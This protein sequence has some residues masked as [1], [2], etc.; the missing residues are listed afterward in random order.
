MTPLET[1]HLTWGEGGGLWFFASFRIFLSDNTRV[2]IFFYFFQNVILGY[3][4]K[5]L[6][7]IIFFPPPK[8]GYFF[9]R[10]WESTYCFKHLYSLK[11]INIS[12]INNM[13]RAI[14]TCKHNII[15]TD[16]PSIRLTFPTIVWDKIL[17]S[18]SPCL[19]SKHI[20]ASMIY[21]LIFTVYIFLRCEYINLFLF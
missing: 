2:R 5:T 19:N 13:R 18:A 21:F 1:D 16:D 6:N 7:Q 3:M 9:Q 8:S 15:V 17:I 20:L 11:I 14:K 10:H 12:K 4:T